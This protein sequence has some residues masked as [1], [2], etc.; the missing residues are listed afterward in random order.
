MRQ[1]VDHDRNT[2]W[3]MTVKKELECVT[4]QGDINI[5]KEDVPMHLRKI[6]N[7]KAPG[8]YELHGFW[9]KKFTFLYQAM[10]KHLDDCTQTADVPNWM[11]ESRTVL[12]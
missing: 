10:V 3:T 8:P 7:W 12:I 2:E 11:V 9:L 6:P 5:A 1:P 4:Q